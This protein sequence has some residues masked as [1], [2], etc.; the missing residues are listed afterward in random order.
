METLFLSQDVLG[1]LVENG[2]DK[3]KSAS[4]GKISY[5]VVS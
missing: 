3:P 1:D 2:F 4:N 5:L